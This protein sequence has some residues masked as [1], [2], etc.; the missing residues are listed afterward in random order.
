MPRRHES[1]SVVID[2]Q[3]IAHGHAWTFPKTLSRI[4]VSNLIPYGCDYTVRGYTG[5]I[6]VERK[7]YGDWI[8]CIASDWHRFTKSLLK[9]KKHRYCCVIVEG[10]IGDYIIYSNI[11]H[12]FVVYR[13]AE[14]VA[15]GIPVIFCRDKDLAAR[16]CW[17]FFHQS[18]ERLQ[19]ETNSE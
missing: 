9:L 8:R 17:E 18:I 4:T 12:D 3:E 10:C 15:H 6:G 2:K 5:I 11:G 7:S 16:C 13:T 1:L 19:H 14:I